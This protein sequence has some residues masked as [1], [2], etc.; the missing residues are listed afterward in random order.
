MM[1]GRLWV[2][3][4]ASSTIGEASVRIMLPIDMKNLQQ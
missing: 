1:N 3:A 4:Y 2:F